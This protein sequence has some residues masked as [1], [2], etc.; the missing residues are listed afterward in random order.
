ML[1]KKNGSNQNQFKNR[2]IVK[3]VD[4]VLNIKVH[5]GFHQ[6]K[7]LWNKFLMIIIKMNNNQ[8]NQL[9]KRKYLKIIIQKKKVKISIKT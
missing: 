1:L 9:K 7:N 4:Q 2:L 6:R 8:L 3:I 5:Q